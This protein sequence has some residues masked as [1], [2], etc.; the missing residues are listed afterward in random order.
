MRMQFVSNIFKIQFIFVLTSIPAALPFE[1]FTEN[2]TKGVLNIALTCSHFD[3]FFVSNLKQN[4]NFLKHLL[5]YPLSY[6]LM[7]TKKKIAHTKVY[8]KLIGFSSVECALCSYSRKF[9]FL[10]SLK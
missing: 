1:N 9:Y 3:F 7:E 6:T 4:I 5:Y 8:I 10:Y 2:W